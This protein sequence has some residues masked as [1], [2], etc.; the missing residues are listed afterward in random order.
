[1]EISWW[2]RFAS[3][4]SVPVPLPEKKSCRASCNCTEDNIRWLMMLYI[5][6]HSTYT[7]LI[8]LKLVPPPLWIINTIFQAHGA[9][10]SLPLNSPCMIE[11][12]FSQFPESGFSS[13]FSARCHILRCSALIPEGPKLILTIPWCKL[14]YRN[15]P[16]RNMIN[17]PDFYHPIP[18]MEPILDQ[19]YIRRWVYLYIVQ[20]KLLW[21]F[22]TTS[23]KLIMLSCT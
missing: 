20:W 8:S 23:E 9:V 18:S 21:P 15:L 10:S 14:L 19:K 6:F 4:G 16:I 3:G 7:R 13:H 22:M 1:M 12:T 17:L 5:T 11:T 2:S